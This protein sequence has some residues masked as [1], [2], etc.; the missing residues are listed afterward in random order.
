M[1]LFLLEISKHLVTY[2]RKGRRK[3]GEKGPLRAN[4]DK[5]M[6]DELENRHWHN[7]LSILILSIEPVLNRL[8]YTSRIDQSHY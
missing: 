6:R 2:W 1:N 4:V 3:F 8:N 7:L 5:P